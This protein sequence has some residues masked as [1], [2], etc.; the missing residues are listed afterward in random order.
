MKKK[1]KMEFKL[2]GNGFV[3]ELNVMIDI[4][5]PLNTLCRDVQCL[6]DNPSHLYVLKTSF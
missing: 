2:A 3:F 1:D 5:R 6:H 4:L